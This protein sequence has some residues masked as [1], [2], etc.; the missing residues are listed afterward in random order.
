MQRTIVD[1]Q[2]E[3][4]RKTQQIWTDSVR[5]SYLTKSRTRRDVFVRAH[6]LFEGAGGVRVTAA[7]ELIARAVT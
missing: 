2:I 4:E 7:R 6:L 5:A 3:D 1:S